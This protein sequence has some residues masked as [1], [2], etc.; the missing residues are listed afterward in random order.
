M[1]R[2][3]IK[4]MA[5]CLYSNMYMLLYLVWQKHSLFQMCRLCALLGIKVSGVPSFLSWTN[6]V[7]SRGHLCPHER[8]QEAG[9][10]NSVC[11]WVWVWRVCFMRERRGGREG[12]CKVCVCVYTMLGFNAYA[13]QRPV[14]VH[15]HHSIQFG[16][17][18]HRYEWKGLWCFST[19]W[20]L[21]T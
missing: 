17:F 8:L 9:G 12:E 14:Y 5:W 13:R 21:S 16:C 10:D 18:Q 2:P 19:V 15:V 4:F 20:L 11:V 1:Y 3:H 7:F 6:F